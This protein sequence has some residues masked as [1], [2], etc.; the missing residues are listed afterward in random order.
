MAAIENIRSLTGAQSH[1]DSDSNE[2]RRPLT[3]KLHLYEALYILNRGFEGVMLALKRLEDLG[4]FQQEGLDAYKVL[5][6]RTRAETNEEL[7]T[8]LQAYEEDDSAYWDRRHH[9][10][11]KL[12]KDPDDVFFAARDRKK[13]IKEQ[14]KE[15]QQGLARQSPRKHRQR[16]RKKH[17]K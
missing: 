4:V 15:L 17:R 16:P 14:I 2:S 1:P 9:E 6:E 8:T 10:R 12:L 13:E 3:T 11:E 7:T 5:V